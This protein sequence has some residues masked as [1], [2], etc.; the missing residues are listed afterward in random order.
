MN[1]L[2]MLQRYSGESVPVLREAVG[3]LRRLFPE[4]RLRGSALERTP[5]AHLATRY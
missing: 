3:K 1:E 5:S 2:Q 4:L